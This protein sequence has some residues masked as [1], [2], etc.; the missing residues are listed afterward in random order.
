M[1]AYKYRGISQAALIGSA[2]LLMPLA[3]VAAGPVGPANSPVVAPRAV[4]VAAPMQ[5]PVPE[6]LRAEHA[7]LHAELE[8]LTHAGG[9]TGK[10]A[11]AV[12]AVLQPH[13]VKEEKYALPPLALLPALARGEVTPDMATILPL[14]QVLKRDLPQMLAEHV[15][16]HAALRRLEAAA[17]AENKPEAKRFAT[18]LM[19]HAETEEQVTYPVAILVGEYLQLRLGPAD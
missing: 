18:E 6:A 7:Q 1:I 12:A 5:F 4:A 10:A 11:Q 13:F 2:L 3:A 9:E 14:T 15:Q 17:V 19:H 16:I 8:E